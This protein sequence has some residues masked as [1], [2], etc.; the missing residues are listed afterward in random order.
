MN[1]FLTDTHS[2][3]S[4]GF[5]HCTVLV[6]G[7]A[8]SVYLLANAHKWGPEKSRAIALSICA[9][10]IFWQL[11][12]PFVRLQL[13]NFSKTHDLPL[14]LCN[15]VPFGLLLAY[16]IKN[17]TVWAVLFFWIILG[18]S[19]SLITPTLTETLPH[20]DAIR[21]W[22]VHFGIVALSLFGFKGMQWKL[23]KSDIIYSAIYLNA[24]GLF[25]YF[26]NNVLDS[27]YMF[28]NGKPPGKTFYSLLPEWPYYFIALELVLA[29]G[30]SVIYLLSTIYSKNK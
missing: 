29:F 30:F 26:V 22:V 3:R 18:C 16:F 19:Q 9:I 21:Y 15:I 27:N 2:F 1:A 28:M 20:Y 17:R 23:H 24:L 12:K 25:M 14:H 7:I 5:E 8:L 6:V 4:W 10:M 13:G 11:F